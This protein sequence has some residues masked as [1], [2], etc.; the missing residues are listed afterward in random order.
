[1]NEVTERRALKQLAVE[2]FVFAVILG[3][4]LWK[5]DAIVATVGAVVFLVGVG[6]TVIGVVRSYPR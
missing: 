2:V 1:M 4:A 3:V 6:F 5:G